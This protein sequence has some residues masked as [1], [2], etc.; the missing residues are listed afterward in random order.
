MERQKKEQHIHSA[1]PSVHDVSEVAVFGWQQ[2]AE[3]YGRSSPPY[4][5]PTCF[6]YICQKAMSPDK[7]I[8]PV[9]GQ[10]GADVMDIH[11]GDM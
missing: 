6:T 11:L 4:L 8:S 3:T 1:V 5:G 2:S 10:V 9:H 7:E